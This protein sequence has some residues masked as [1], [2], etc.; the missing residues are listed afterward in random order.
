MG[1]RRAMG[2]KTS[3]LT[4]EVVLEQPREL[5]GRADQEGRP[6]AGVAGEGPSAKGAAAHDERKAIATTSASSV[7][8]NQ[9]S[10][11]QSR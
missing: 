1:R 2:M 3:P 9:R 8:K 7:K 11:L 4:L 5:A 6:V 10:S